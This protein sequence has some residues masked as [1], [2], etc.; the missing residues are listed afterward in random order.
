MNRFEW[1]FKD[2]KG[3]EWQAE[4]KDVLTAGGSNMNREETAPI[5]FRRT[6]EPQG[7][8]FKTR[9]TRRNLNKLREMDDKKR[10]SELQRYLKQAMR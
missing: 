4:V 5:K 3:V 9:I 2:E 6:S 10:I 1:K 8:S 7:Q